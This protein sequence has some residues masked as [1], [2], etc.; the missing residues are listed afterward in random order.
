MAFAKIEVIV[1]FISNCVLLVIDD[2]NEFNPLKTITSLMLLIQRLHPR[3]FQ[4]EE[5]GYIDRLYGT[6]ELRVFAAQNKPIDFLPA[7]WAK[8]V[9][10]FSEFR[11]SF[12]I[13]K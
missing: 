9:Y 12:L 8:D 11:K 5:N 10:K 13:Y 6:N 7:T 2:I 3:E 4:W 1:L